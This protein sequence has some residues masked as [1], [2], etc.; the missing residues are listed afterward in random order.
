MLIEISIRCCL[1]PYRTRHTKEDCTET[2][3]VLNGTEEP[4]TSSRRAIKVCFIVSHTVYTRRGWNRRRTVL[5]RVHG[6][7]SV[8]KTTVIAGQGRPEEED[9]HHSVELPETRLLVPFYIGD[10]ELD[11]TIDSL[12]GVFRT[13][14]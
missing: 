8:E 13:L 1:L 14:L 4:Q 7:K 6:L 2:S 12:E 9:G 3:D 10:M 5:P 11:V